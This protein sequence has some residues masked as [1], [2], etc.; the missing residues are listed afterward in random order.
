MLQDAKCYIRKWRL[1]LS[2]LLLVS[3][4]RKVG[5]PGPLCQRSLPQYGTGRSAQVA[6]YSKPTSA[7]F[8][9]RDSEFQNKKIHQY[10][11]PSR[12]FFLTSLFKCYKQ[13]SSSQDVLMTS[14]F[15]LWCPIALALR[16]RWF[17]RKNNLIFIFFF[18]T[19]VSTVYS[20]TS[21]Y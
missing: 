2:W 6:K 15:T 1:R 12:L 18:V 17:S 8:H 21:Q 20:D 3:F 7:K 19:P 13:K 10:W 11:M 4:N 9:Q 5:I 16:F 14:D